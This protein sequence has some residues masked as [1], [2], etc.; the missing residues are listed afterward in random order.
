MG[1]QLL[2]PFRLLQIT[3][4]TIAGTFTCSPIASA[5]QAY[6]MIMSL[7]PVAAQQGK[8]STLTINS[9][10][11]MFGA[12]KVWISGTGVTAKVITPMKKDKKGNAPKL[13]KVQ[14]ELTVTANALPGVRDFRIATPNGTSTLGQLVITRD[15]VTYEQKKNNTIAE[16]QT[17]SLPA[18]L[19]GAIERTEDVDFF[20]FH[21]DA[22]QTLCF[23]VRCARLQDKIHDL[24]IHADPII[25]IKNDS[26]ST[27]AT[28]DNAF[29]GDPFICHKFQQAGDYYLEIR[30][31]RY[32][33]HT[34]WEYSIEVNDRPF[35]TTLFPLG[36]P[37]QKS[38]SCTLIGHHLSQQK[39]NVIPANS[40]PLGIQPLAVSQGKKKTNPV[41]VVLHDLPQVIETDKE[42]NLFNQAQPITAPAGVNGRIEKQGDID[43]YTFKAKKGEY[44]SFE[45]IARRAG[46]ALDP[47]I[48]ILD[49]KGNRR[50]ENDDLR[51]GKRGFADSWIENL[52]A[53]ADGVYTVEIRDVHLRGGTDFVYFLK[54]TKSK[55]YFELFLDTDKTQ[56]TPHTNGVIF[57]NAVRKNNFAGEIQLQIKG[58][59]KGVTA[60]CGRILAKEKIGCIIL[61][62]KA[63]LLPSLTNIEVHGTAKHLVENQKPLSLISDAAVYQE[64]YLPG[65]GRGHWPVNVHTV[66]IAPPSDILSVK[67]KQTEITLTPGGTTRVDV[68]IIRAKGFEKNV[69]LDPFFQHLGSIFGRTIPKGITVDAKKSKTILKGKETKGYIVFKADAAV[70]PFEKQQVSITANISI[71]FVMKATYSS[72]PLLV[73]VKKK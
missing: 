9:R 33:K 55:P 49:S 61:S 40:L 47:I 57:V 20:K 5:Q 51:L 64:I 34:Y 48:R 58:L 19:C 23:H 44:F 35:V 31:V 39:V 30:D 10:Y 22:N 27:V 29:F 18:T 66:S 7:K 25:S 32:Q 70:L 69:Q 11:T 56:L 72:N 54:I 73:T 43:C 46:S 62:A 38:T 15:A 8:T 60:S 12:N 45:V 16:A 37:R 67:V 52:V 50:S 24:Q 42:N 21:I 71:N 36:L 6:P 26:G 28:S 63:G 59:P 4:I 68:E 53:P 13:Q 17:V 65:G 3:L 41:A 1:V 2:F 14:I